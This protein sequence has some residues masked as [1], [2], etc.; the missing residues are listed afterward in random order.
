MIQGIL[1]SAV[2]ILTYV[3]PMI[4]I[5]M[6]ILTQDTLVWNELLL[7]IFFPL[8]GFFNGLIYL[9]PFYRKKKREWRTKKK[10][11]NSSNKNL[12]EFNSQH[13]P[14]HDDIDDDK[15]HYRRSSSGTRLKSSLRSSNAS[16]TSSRRFSI[17][18]FTMQYKWWEQEFEIVQ[19]SNHSNIL[20]NNHNDGH[21]G[22]DGND[23]QE[24]AIELQSKNEYEPSSLQL[25]EITALSKIMNGSF[26]DSSNRHS[27]HDHEGGENIHH[28]ISIPLNEIVEDDYDETLHQNRSYHNENTKTTL[29]FDG[30]TLNHNNHSSN[31]D[32]GQFLSRDEMNDE[33][34]NEEEESSISYYDCNSNSNNGI[35]YDHECD[36]ESQDEF[37]HMSKLYYDQENDD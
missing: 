13:S 5:V 12:K 22:N 20:G 25:N 28:G 17:L 18:G 2:L 11:K 16:R 14:L 34:N 36:S 9:I 15:D 27:H 32:L 29:S 21:D 23:D 31:H 33:R 37:M 30:Q 10:L 3:F 4:G 19:P 7:S 26:N 1:Y 24:M 35:L 8:Q 6:W